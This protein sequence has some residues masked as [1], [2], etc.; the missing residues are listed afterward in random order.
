[1]SHALSNRAS[2]PDCEAADGGAPLLVLVPGAAAGTTD[3]AEPVILGLRLSQRIGLAARAAGYR[4]IVQLSPDQGAAPSVAAG[5]DWRGVAALAATGRAPALVIAPTTLLGDTAWFRHLAAVAVQAHAWAAA[6]QVILLPAAIARDALALLEAGGAAFD[7]ATIQDRLIGRFG[8]PAELPADLAPT[9]VVTAEDVDA[10]ERRLLRSVVK[11]TDGFMARHVE[12]P[13]SLAIS[14]R[15]C[16]T[17]VTPNQMT[18]VS[19]AIGL[20]SAPFFLSASAAWQTLGA[21]LLLAHSILD[22]CDGELARLRFQASRWGG[23]LDFWADNIVH[24]VTFAC[25]ALGW[26]RASGSVVPLWLGAA[27]VLG[28]L[29][30]AG[31]VYWRVM[32]RKAGASPAYTSVS[33]APDRPLARVLDALSR[34]DFIYLVL[35]LALFGKVSWFLLLAAFGAPI[36]FFLVLVLAWRERAAAASGA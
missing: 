19:L 34:R 25:M 28:T 15:L 3:R 23:V 21:L 33:T 27:A 11:E 36:F 12:R 8:R 5:A 24:G 4:T 13:I 20:A 1:M 7:L 10:A 30:S 9:V 2:I 26:S 14:R 16:A 18:L 6:G 17:R 22:G 31:F 35:A 32:R 29:G